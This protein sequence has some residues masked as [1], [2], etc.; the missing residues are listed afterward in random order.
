MGGP[1]PADY[2]IVVQRQCFC[3]GPE[4]LGPVRVRVRGGA[5]VERTYETDGSP[6]PAPFAATFPA[7][8]G[9]FE[10]IE[11]AI[12]RESDHLVVIFDPELGYPVLAFADYVLEA[13]D[14]EQGYDVVAFEP[15]P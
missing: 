7:V 12:D 2:D 1:G 15:V 14:E 4:A 3:G 11:D 10:F 6:V 8:E 13:A 9:L 5:I